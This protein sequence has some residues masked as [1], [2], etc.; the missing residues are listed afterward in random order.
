MVGDDH[1]STP[2]KA[3]R[4]AEEAAAAEPELRRLHMID[5]VYSAL[6][7]GEPRRARRLLD[8]IGTSPSDESLDRRLRALRVWTGRLEWNCYPG[9]VGAEIPTFDDHIE[10]SSTGD[11]ETVLI[12]HLVAYGPASI[13]IR[14]Q[15]GGQALRGR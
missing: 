1:M 3:R 7:A 15:S 10:V 12:E 9:G 13:L 14:A 5:L 8:E 6:L 2:A 11:A 4:A